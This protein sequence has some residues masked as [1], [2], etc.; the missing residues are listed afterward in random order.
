MWGALLMLLQ[1][2]GGMCKLS[3]CIE[4]NVG[5]VPVPDDR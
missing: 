4:P 2:P 5:I 3:F 1:G